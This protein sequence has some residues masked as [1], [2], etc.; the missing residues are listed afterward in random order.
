MIIALYFFS[1]HWFKV[2]WNQGHSLVIHPPDETK[3][4]SGF[5][6]TAMWSSATLFRLFSDFIGAPCN[7]LA[8]LVPV[9]WILFFQFSSH[10]KVTE[11]NCQQRPW[12]VYPAEL[13]SIGVQHYHL[14]HTPLFRSLLILYLFL[15]THWN[16]EE[17]L[18][19]NSGPITLS[20]IFSFFL[21][22]TS[23]K[24]NVLWRVSLFHQLIDA[25]HNS[26]QKSFSGVH[27][28]TVVSS[29]DNLTS[30]HQ[31]SYCYQWNE[32]HDGGFGNSYRPFCQ[33]Q[34]HIINQTSNSHQSLANLIMPIM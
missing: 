8:V 16:R 25:H 6:H 10:C 2:C 29:R 11:K 9:Y 27:L 28:S 30:V 20:L 4:V 26:Q 32:V 23:I 5:G 17:S 12:M 1:R 21:A 24:W 15:G 19:G 3:I 31:K 14:I 13:L 18:E 22:S 33:L 34:A 7:R